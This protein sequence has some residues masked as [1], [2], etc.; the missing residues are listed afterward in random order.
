KLYKAE[1]ANIA[2]TDGTIAASSGSDRLTVTVT[3]AA[4]TRLVVTGSAAQTAGAAQ[5][6][7]VTAT[8][9]YGNTDLTYSGAKSLTY[10]GAS[11]STNPVT[12]PTVTNSTPTATNFGSATTNTFT[13]GVSNTAGGVGSMKL[14][15]VETANIAVTDGTIA[16]STGTDRLT[17]AVTAAAA[18]RL[19]NPASRPHNTRHSA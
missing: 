18:S 10:S 4:A 13:N 9:P 12:A 2:V 8:D 19:L 16:A 7:T 5:T 3:A 15:K 11:S 6:V 17:V 14:Y 1:T